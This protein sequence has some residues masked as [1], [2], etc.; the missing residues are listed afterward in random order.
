[1]RVRLKVKHLVLFVLLPLSL[2]AI[3][4]V[5]LPSSIARS[6]EPDLSEALR[7]ASRDELLANLEMSKGSKRMEL[8]R[9]EVLYP[10]N[11]LYQFNAYIGPS[12]SH[13]S[14]SENEEAPSPLL[15]EDRVRLLREYISEGPVDHTLVSAVKQL[16]YELEV[17][18][19]GNDA[20]LVLS[21]ASSRISS[22]T[23]T[24]QELQLLQAERAL[25]AGD[26]AAAHKLLL[27]ELAEAQADIAGSYQSTELAARAAW[28]KGRLLFAEGKSGEALTLVK[29]ALESYREKW[30]NLKLD[31]ASDEPQQEGGGESS[32]GHITEQ[33][34]RGDTDAENQLIA[35]RRALESAVDM[36]LTAPATVEGTLTKS[37]GTPVA[38][39]GIFLRE[40]SEL[41]HSVNY[42]SE[43]YQI[44]TDESGHFQFNGVLPGFYQLEIGV[45][46]EQI[47]GWAWPVQS[48]DWIEIKPGDDLTENIILQ[49]LL[50]LKSPVNSQVVTGSSVE[51]EWEAVKGAAYYTLNG[52]VS[53]EGNFLTTAIRQNIKDNKVSIPAEALYDAGGFSTSSSGN[54]WQSIDPASLLRFADSENRFSWTIEAFDEQGKLLTRSNGYR[55]NEETVGNL[56]FFY[57]KS[58]TLTAADQLVKDKKLE[59]AL[60]AY[61]RD[62]TAD[63]QDAHALKMLTHL[64]T[65]K[66]SY[67]NDIQAMNATIPLLIKLA[68]LRPNA[69]YAFSLIDHYFEQSDW[70]NYNKYYS[71]YNELS[72][73]EPSSYVRS[74]HATALMFQG[75]L[76]E[77]RE[78]F[79][80]ALEEDDSHRF[81]G[82][83]LA[84]ELAAGEPLSSV[85]ELAKRYPEHGYETS[86]YQWQKLISGLQSERAVQPEAF[87]SL[88]RE[89]LEAYLKDGTGGSEELLEWTRTGEPSALKNFMKAVLEVS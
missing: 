65:A 66:A 71:Q 50:E 11:S 1:M 59:Q 75:Q 49:P 10:G 28:L 53:S 4:A 30:K 56:P 83:Y 73:E 89:K 84:A 85:L 7:E 64:L 12:M 6:T 21:E 47:D 29:S 45:S 39:A 18:R 43:P 36:G 38:R 40:E 82:S 77:A 70:V 42:G 55:L 5:V 22:R 72:L 20:D 86:G 14:E 61:R 41:Y 37:D 87:D 13:W 52:T 63:P 60:E 8:I 76:A 54:G 15:P 74:I 24:S 19:G 17:H 3:M 48:D 26:Y 31:W 69:N 68:E 16:I 44:V 78:Q 46:F 81:I 79:S 80:I 27:P 51:F 32:P 88:M 25:N 33:P 9:T 67:T 23:A 57:Y 34:E 35:L 58:R 62:Y 2:L